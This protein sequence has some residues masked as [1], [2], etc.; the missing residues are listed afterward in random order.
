MKRLLLLLTLM[1]SLSTPGPAQTTYGASGRENIEWAD[2]WVTH[3]RESALPRVLLIGDSITRGYEGAVEKKLEGKAYVARLCTSCFDTDPALISYISIVLQTYQFD[4]I[5][6]N[7]G[8]HGWGHSEAEYAQGLPTMLATIRK[9]APKAKLIW[10]NTT[11]LN[12]TG[13]ITP[14]PTDAAKA[15][16]GKLMLQADLQ[17]KSNARVDARN[18]IAAQLMQA[19]H[20]PINDLHSL[21]LGHPELYNGDVHFNAKGTELQATHVADMIGKAL[22]K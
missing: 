15:D 11:P 3:A 7:N 2:I 9:Y 17:G 4:V 10:A 1:A 18:A 20:I 13:A 6:F 16:A 5:Q 19:E 8:M 12:E 14:A 21:V 22:V